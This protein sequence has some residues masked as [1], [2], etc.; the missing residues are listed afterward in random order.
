MN[1][2]EN[3]QYTDDTIDLV[4]LISA[5][6]QMRKY[7]A[8]GAL[9]GGV[10]GLYYV[11]AASTP[12]HQ[13]R[14]SI[15]VD[16]N[17]L[18]AVRDSKQIAAL[19]SAALNSPEIAFLAFSAIEKASPGFETALQAKG[20]SFLTL[21]TSVSQ[22]DK[23]NLIPLKLEESPS[24]TDFNI[25]L[26]LP[27]GGLGPNIGSAVI[28]SVNI[29]SKEYNKRVLQSRK[30]ESENLIAEA[31]EALSLSDANLATLR[32]EVE[33]EL[34]TVRS[35]IGAIE[36]RLHKQARAS[37]I[38][39][40]AFVSAEKIGE[41][42]G[43]IIQ[44]NSGADSAKNLGSSDTQSS[45]NIDRAT[46][47]ISSLSEEGGLSEKEAANL[48]IRITDLR[49][50]YQ[51]FKS[52]QV[53]LRAAEKNHIER[54][55]SSMQMNITPIDRA[56]LYL[57]QF[58]LNDR[59]YQAGLSG[60]TFERSTGRKWIAV[61]LGAFVGAIVSGGIWILSMFFKKNRERLWADQ[62]AQSK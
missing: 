33:N 16:A 32:S 30:L 21:A 52:Q 44:I 26:Q 54:L 25:Q 6:W 13:S 42:N 17:S 31:K 39:M 45:L 57:P 58:K 19:F 35:Q 20:G 11:F 7:V 41:N 43:S 1:Q 9:F 10:I 51:K 60:G 62:V 28:E 61:L 48:R 56:V 18:P 47:L 4:E 50:K 46:F 14:I 49:V 59:L 37:K 53:S 34:A 2:Q 22:S 23:V 8:C 27:I 55:Y 40:S 3:A 24:S 5:M 15:T 12:L 38:D 36:Y 29:V